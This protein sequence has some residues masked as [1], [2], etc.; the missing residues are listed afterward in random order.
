MVDARTP[1]LHELKSQPQFFSE[2][3]NGYKTHD[4]RL[5]DRDY[6]VG[7][8]VWLREWNPET[9]EYTGRELIRTITYI[10]DVDSPC[11]YSPAAL[12]PDFCIL[13]IQ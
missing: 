6:A 4:L 10:T 13:S 1:I 2:I 3:K 12:H 5:R 7:D 11:A 9:G 8:I